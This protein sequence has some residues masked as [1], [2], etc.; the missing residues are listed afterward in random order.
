MSSLLRDRPAGSAAMLAIFADEAV[1]RGALDFEA[2]LAAAQAAE[3]LIG[4]ADAT[5]I[6]AVCGSLSPD[7]D[8]LAEEAAHAGTLAIPLVARL[9]AALKAA[10]PQAATA[11]HRGA[12][13]QDLADTALMLQARAA[14][15][16]LGTDAVRLEAA[17]AVLSERHAATPMLGRTLLQSALPITFGLKTAGWLTGLHAARIRVER[18]AEAALMLQ[19]GGAAGTLAGIG[20]GETALA[21]ARRMAETLGLGMP[22]TP[23]H[24]RRQAIAA[25]GAALAILT[26]TAGKMARD[27]SL[28]AQNE[29][30]EAFEPRLPGRGG[31]SAM[32]HKRN[33]TGCQVALSAALRAPGLAATLFAGLPQEHERGLGGWQAEG[34]VL[35]DLFI[36]THGAVVAMAD[37]AEG[38]EVDADAMARNLA[39][40]DVGSDSGASALLVG[41]ALAALPGALG[42]V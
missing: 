36:L 37:V 3:G 7:I 8:A 18:E 23:W 32:A 24:A 25:L 16:L 41:R 9:R 20:D 33:P 21:V 40:A 29:V 42:E 38:L 30:A 1:L 13:S 35:A 31:S 15:T 39:S 2:A 17:L 4:E 19:L 28:L 34:P 11:V 27:I 10:H 26:G 22:V 5:A 12:T 6:G 14:M